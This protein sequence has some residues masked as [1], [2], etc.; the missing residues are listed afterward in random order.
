MKK[1]KIVVSILLIIATLLFFIVPLIVNGIFNYGNIIRIGTYNIQV[2]GY[3]YFAIMVIRK[4]IQYGLLLA[5][6]VFNMFLKDKPKMIFN[7]II[8]FIMILVVGF[9]L[10]TIIT[11][12]IGLFDVS[13]ITTIYVFIINDI[14][15][16]FITISII[17]YIF[18]TIPNGSVIFFVNTIINVAL[19]I[20]KILFTIVIL[21]M[22][23]GGAFV[24]NA[25]YDIFYIGL[26]I[27]TDLLL[28]YYFWKNE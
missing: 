23:S 24:L 3:L 9:N 20:A 11:S 27:T 5:F 15:N 25:I 16:V 18:N 13:N 17:V 1:S 12:Y 14:I 6:L 7:A 22:S 26:L 4:I 21:F 10:I 2:A 28:I 8:G 19:I